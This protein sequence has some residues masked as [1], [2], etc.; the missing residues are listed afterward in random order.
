MNVPRLCRDAS[1]TPGIIAEDVP[2]A[3]WGLGWFHGRDRPLQ[4][5]L[6]AAVGRGG[7]AEHVVARPQTL[8]IDRLVHRL[9]LVRIGRAQAQRLSERATIWI[10]AYLDGLQSG[11]TEGGRPFEL[12][13]LMANVPPPNRATLLTSF[14]F[15]SYVGLAQSQG[16]MERAIV[17][18]LQA[19]ADPSLLVRM[20]DPH[21]DGWDVHALR[22]VPLAPLPAIAA[23]G[24]SNAWAVTGSRTNSGSAMLAG[25][26]HLQINQLPS[27]FHEVRAKVGDDFW[28]GA[29]IP[30]LPGLALGRNKNVGWSATFAVAD[31]VD[32]AIEPD[33]ARARRTVSLGRRFNS[34]VPVAFHQGRFGVTDH[35][36]GAGLSS[37]W[38]GVDSAAVAL[39]SFLG[40]LVAQSAS[41]AER[42]LEGASNFSLHFV[43]ADRDGD[44][45][46]TQ[47]GRVPRRTANWSGLYPVAADGPRRWDGYYEGESMPRSGPVDDIVASAN[48]ARLATDGGVLST[49][50]QPS[51]RLDRIRARLAERQDHDV[52]TFEALQL[53]LHSLQGARFRDRF[54]EALGAGPLTDVLCGWDLRCDTSSRGAHAF[55]IAYRAALSSLMPALGGDWFEHALKTT[56]LSVWWCA[57]LDRAL[58]QVALDLSGVAG[59]EA[60]PWGEVQT[61]TL[62]NMI[63]GGLPSGFGFDAGPFALGGSISTVCQGNVITLDG[64]E[65]AIGPA[66]RFVTDMH[67]NEAYTCLPG[68]IDGSRFSRTYKCWLDDWRSG[69]YHPIR[70]PR[71]DEAVVR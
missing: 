27:L 2:Q 70:P 71:Y 55:A 4:S 23:A 34:R 7:L 62:P 58:A 49:L 65:V 61:L 48:E 16:R 35:P 31:N 13:V 68:G 11:L 10:D 17:E 29:S 44:V 8:A 51:Y 28:L 38:A 32:W 46:Y 39:D 22:E 45:R 59:N 63:L 69:R 1:G 41:D 25:D 43:L 9:D 36:S 52:A 20:F 21:L 18:A 5:L 50:A 67:D 26:P 12:K 3:M 56:E 15:S 30:G 42:T 47:T 57:A 40:L 60:R 24:G 37:A 19:G 53:D 66:Y 54:V 33:E 64:G 6:L 14:L